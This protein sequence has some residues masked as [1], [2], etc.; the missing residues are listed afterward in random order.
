MSKYDKFEDFMQTV[1]NDADALCWSVHNKS[2]A[3]AYNVDQRAVD[4]TLAIIKAGW[5]AFFALCALFTLGGILFHAAIIAFL[6]TPIGIIVTA[7]LAAFGGVPAAR[8]LSKMYMNKV[9]PQA[10]RAIGEMYKADF[11]NHINEYSYIDNLIVKASRT[12]L[13]KA[14]K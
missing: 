9:L 7:S 5:K 1:I 12:L 8:L 14:T 6:T 11:E 13:E 10:V 2:L 4:M 3:D